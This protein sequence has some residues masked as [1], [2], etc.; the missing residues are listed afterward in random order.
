MQVG[1]KVAVYESGVRYVGKVI[2]PGGYLFAEEGNILVEVQTD[3]GSDTIE[4]HPRQCTKLK[5]KKSVVEGYVNLYA[6]YIGK[7]FKTRQEAVAKAG[8]H[9]LE[10]GVRLIRAKDQKAA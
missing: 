8:D 2:D 7:P 4:V 6:N 3:D 9:C 1:D 10:A 5:A